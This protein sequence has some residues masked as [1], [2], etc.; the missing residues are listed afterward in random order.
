MNYPTL[1]QVE[2][3]DRYD[4]GKWYRYLPS[5][6]ANS[7]NKPRATFQEIMEKEVVIMNRIV[8]RFK[9]MGFFTPEL[10]KSLNSNPY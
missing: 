2:A 6:G 9:A 10:S 1:E 4:L 7:I 8:A 3:A 5:P